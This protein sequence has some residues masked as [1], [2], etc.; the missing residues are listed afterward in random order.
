MRSGWPGASG[1]REAGSPGER[2][3]LGPG[4]P[5]VLAP[6]GAPTGLAVAPP[7]GGKGRSPRARSGLGGQGK[8][9]SPARGRRAARA[10]P[11]VHCGSGGTYLGTERA[12]VQRALR[13]CPLTVSV[14]TAPSEPGKTRILFICC[15]GG[16]RTSR[17]VPL[18]RRGREGWRMG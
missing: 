16:T 17:P 8:L 7:G 2:G 12:Q 11:G 5:P 14:Q 3:L 6:R 9:W 1:A 10:L 18:V 4:R 13:S 15:G